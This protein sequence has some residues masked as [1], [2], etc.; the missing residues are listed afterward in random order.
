MSASNLLKRRTKTYLAKS[1]GAR[2]LKTSVRISSG[3]LSS[4]TFM[5]SDLK[6]N[7]LGYILFRRKATKMTFSTTSNEVASRSRRRCKISLSALDAPR[8]IFD[9]VSIW[10]PAVRCFRLGMCHI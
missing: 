8:I 2:K 4:G 1:F 6:D 7:S 5:I 3:K 9:E 10:Y